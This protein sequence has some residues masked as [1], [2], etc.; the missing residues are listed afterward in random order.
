MVLVSDVLAKRLVWSG[1]FA[2]MTAPALWLFY[3]ASTDQ[4]GADPAK[5][6]VD[7]LGQWAFRFLII[8]LCAS[9]F[10][11]RLNIRVLLQ[12]RRMLGV[13]ALFYAVLHLLAVSTFILGWR[14]DLLTRELTDRPYI[15]LGMASLLLLI[16]LG[17]TS[18][19]G[20]QKRM[21][22]RWLALHKLI[23]PAALLALL[24]LVFLIR[25]SVLEAVIYTFCI[26]A[27]LI[28][29]LFRKRKPKKREW[30][31]A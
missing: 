22:R 31:K 3:L 29:R 13:F 30:S 27:L 20:W 9:T 7:D 17:V 6:I 25:A 10:S 26:S 11:R 8:T 2:L 23:Y 19:K 4:L 5:E 15:M 16:P 18:T 14:V 28:E 24:H 21:G 12:H 1:M